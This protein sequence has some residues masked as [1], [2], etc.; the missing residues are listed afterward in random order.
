VKFCKELE[1]AREAWLKAA[2]GSAAKRNARDEFV[3]IYAG[4]GGHFAKLGLQPPE[5]VLDAR[6]RQL[7]A[8]VYRCN[9]LNLN[10]LS[11][12]ISLWKS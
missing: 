12:R 2:R 10:N 11:R 8:V 7:L 1:E 5:A 3:R 9:F 4:I 6:H